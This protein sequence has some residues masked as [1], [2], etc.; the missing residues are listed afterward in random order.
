MNAPSSGLSRE[1]AS[2]DRDPAFVLYSLWGNL[3]TVL[4][5]SGFE[6]PPTRPAGR[7]IVLSMYFS[8]FD[9]AISEKKREASVEYSFFV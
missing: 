5:V 8:T 6:P 3:S 4:S 1:F 2:R 7:L 9:F